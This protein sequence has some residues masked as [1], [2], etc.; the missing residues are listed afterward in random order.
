VVD[1]AQAGSLTQ[2]GYGCGALVTVTGPSLMKIL[3]RIEPDILRQ[4]PML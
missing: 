2:N 4:I 3:D 1:E